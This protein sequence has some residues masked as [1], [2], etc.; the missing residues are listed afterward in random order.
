MIPRLW[1]TPASDELTCAALP[2][3][4]RLWTEMASSARHTIL[5]DIDP[6]DKGTGD[7]RIVVETPKGSRNK[8]DYDP[9]CDCLQLA[10]VLP[11][12]M[13]FPYDF[14]FIPGTLGDDG[15]PL[16]VL[17]LMDAPVVPGC[18]ITARLVGAIE[19]EQKEKKADWIRNDR[20]IAVATH[21]KTYETA[22]RLDD[23]RPHLMDEIREFFVDYNKLE[24][25]KF[26]AKAEVGPGKA[27]GL[28]AN[29]IRKFKDGRRKR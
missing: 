8:Y 1:N 9:D 29:G 7:L 3:D 15:D 28:I 27:K 13:I 24:G 14:G 21:A 18:V 22:K 6:H 23:L 17:V 19:A 12:G 10:K 2:R 25:R 16:D 11:E 20:L 5:S 26:E 4:E